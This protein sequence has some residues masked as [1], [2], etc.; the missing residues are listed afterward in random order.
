MSFSNPL[1]GAL[2][3][4]LCVILFMGL[5]FMVVYAPNNIFINNER[6]LNETNLCRPFSSTV[7][8]VYHRIV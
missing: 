8:I 7:Q 3:F 2:Y 1:I 5:R 4:L 6:K